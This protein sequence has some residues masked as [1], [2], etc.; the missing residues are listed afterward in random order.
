MIDT[1]LLE[2]Q[3]SVDRPA[4]RHAADVRVRLTIVNGSGSAVIVL[5]PQPGS[6]SLAF[7]ASGGPAEI[8]PATTLPEEGLTAEQRLAPGER[9]SLEYPLHE[10][11]R[12]LGAS[13][14]VIRCAVRLEYRDTQPDSHWESRQFANEVALEVTQ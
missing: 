9:V 6:Q 4:W 1:L 10:R 8:V 7:D 2:A 11:V 3:F 13:A 5:L 14:Y 12:L